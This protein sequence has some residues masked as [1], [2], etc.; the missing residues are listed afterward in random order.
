MGIRG[1]PS[2]P[3]DPSHGYVWSAIIIQVDQPGSQS[4]F[5]SVADSP[6]ELFHKHPWSI[7]GGGIAELK[8]SLDY[9]RGSQLG[10]HLDVVGPMVI[11]G[12]EEVFVGPKNFCKRLKTKFLPYLA[13]D[14]IRD[15]RLYDELYIV[16]PYDPQRQV[17]QL[18]QTGRFEVLAYTYRTYLKQRTMFGKTPSESG[19]SWYEYRYFEKSRAATLPLITFAYVST[20]NQFSYLNESVIANQHATVMRLS[21]NRSEE[22]YFRILGLL[23]SSTACFW[24]KQV[25]HNK[26]STVDE[27]GARQTTVAFE[28]FYEFTGTGLQQFPVTPETPID[29]AINLD[30]LAQVWQRCLPLQLAASFPLSQTLLVEHKDKAANL[31]GRMVALQEELD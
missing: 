26:G 1:E 27:K 21:K 5:V 29:L 15:W 24:M 2:T 6:R 19:L 22:D 31:L 4:E 3:G 23:N 7:G 16:Y 11:M 20:H 25:F 28:N 12:L 9:V 10:K 30:R 14:Q 13:G 17:V 18:S 8:D